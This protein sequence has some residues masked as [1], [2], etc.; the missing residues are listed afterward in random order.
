[1]FNGSSVGGTTETPISETPNGLLAADTL[2]PLSSG[3]PYFRGNILQNNDL[4]AME[5]LGDVGNGNREIENVDVNSLWDSTDITYLVRDSIVLGPPALFDYSAPVPSTTALVAEPKPT[6]V[7]TVQSAL[8]GTLQPDGTSIPKPGESVI[9]KLSNAVAPL[10]TTSYQTGTVGTEDS[11]GAGFISGHDNGVDPTGDPYVD[12]GAGSQMRFLGIGA[13]QTTGQIR[14]PVIITSIHDSTVG[15]TVRGVTMDQVITGDT[16]APAAG[17]GG[18]IYFGGNELPNY[19][20]LDP[21]AGSIIDNVD[22]RYITRI[23]MQGGGII[24]YTD[25]NASNSFDAADNFYATKGGSFPPLPNGQPNPAS[26]AVQANAEHS[27][28][29]S[30]SNLSSFSDAGIITHPGF[31]ELVSSVPARSADS[32]VRFAGYSVRHRRRT[33]LPCPHQRH[34]LE[35]ASRREHEGRPELG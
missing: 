7:L 9:I 20:L 16:Q 28:L 32:D 2:R 11:A 10:P 33:K 19:N 21:R 31:N 15:T 24:A 25:A 23:E 27:L 17:D 1:M 8:P 30:N 5:V 35:Y 18:L 22:I 12:V 29:I 4:N 3:A 34:R 14:V 13:N 6:V 26:Y